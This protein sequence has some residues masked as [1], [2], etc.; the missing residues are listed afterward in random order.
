[1]KGFLSFF[2]VAVSLLGLRGQNTSQAY[3]D[4]IEKYKDI[5]VRQMRSERIPASI[6]L[7]QGLLES[8]AGTSFLAVEANNHFGI[9]CTSD[10]TGKSVRKDDDRRNECFRKYE[11]V[12]D[13]YRDHSAFL[14]RDRYASLYSLDP[15]DYQ[16]W[17]KGLKAAGYA[18]D[19]LYAEKLIRLIE[20][21]SLHELDLQGAEQ[22]LV[23]S[24][25][26]AHAGAVSSFSADCDAIYRHANKGMLYVVAF[27][28]D[29]PWDI[30]QRFDVPLKKILDYNEL[31]YD[32]QLI[33][34]QY[35]FLVKKKTSGAEPFYTVAQGDTMYSIAQKLGM[36]VESLYAKNRIKAGVQPPVGTKLYLKRTIPRRLAVND[37]NI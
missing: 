3:R 37:Y 24:A 29:T 31:R 17:A 2:L 6:I 28:G 16:A 26:T 15:T 9:K 19:P 36:T 25:D 30:A 35:L 5:A 8:A 14:K 33:P 23:V 18:T 4:Y 34:G 21:Y 1:M 10:W 32:S 12:E 7:A 27:P 13:S 22:G 20:N 11:Q